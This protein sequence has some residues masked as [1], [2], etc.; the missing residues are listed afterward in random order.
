M[1][2]SSPGPPATPSAKECGGARLERQPCPLRGQ[3]RGALGGPIEF[4]YEIRG[5][6]YLI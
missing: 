3:S 5:A 4:E 1:L 2:G 6:G